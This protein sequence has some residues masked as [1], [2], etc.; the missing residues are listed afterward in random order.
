MLVMVFTDV[1]WYLFTT[2]PLDK[3]ASLQV[4]LKASLKGPKEK[5]S[6]SICKLIEQAETHLFF[7]TSK[8]LSCIFNGFT[9]VPA[10]KSCAID[11]DLGTTVGVVTHLTRDGEAGADLGRADACSN[12]ASG[13]RNVR[14]AFSFG[15]RNWMKNTLRPLICSNLEHNGPLS[16]VRISHDPAG[17]LKSF[18]GFLD[19]F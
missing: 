19:V 3:P 9:S 8:C 14:S 10:L 13:A 6:S 18:T 2:H 1:G 4:A 11:T 7:S 17:A 16:D 15:S 12:D 5:G